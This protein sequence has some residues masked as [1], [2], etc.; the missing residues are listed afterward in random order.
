MRRLIDTLPSMNSEEFHPGDQKSDIRKVQTQLGWTPRREDRGRLNVDQQLENGSAELSRAEIL[1]QMISH[2]AS[3]YHPS[4]VRSK[5]ANGCGPGQGSF[6]P[7]SLDQ[8][9]LF[10]SASFVARISGC[11]R[12]VAGGRAWQ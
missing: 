11:D 8:A 10:S 6:I 3:S 1:V 4:G 12:G 2:P 7:S 5:P 9:S